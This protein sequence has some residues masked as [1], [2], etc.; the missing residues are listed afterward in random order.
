VKLDAGSLL[1][2]PTLL[3]MHDEGFVSII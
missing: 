3:A 1:L 2:Y